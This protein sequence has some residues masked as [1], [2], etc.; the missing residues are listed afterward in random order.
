MEEESHPQSLLPD[1]P[2]IIKSLNIF[3]LSLWLAGVLLGHWCVLLCVYVGDRM[4]AALFG[5]FWQEIVPKI[6]FIL[7][8]QLFR[9]WP[10]CEDHSEHRFLAII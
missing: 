8:I 1:M 7:Q 3:Y 9:F 2:Q 5:L 6:E 4:G 10:S